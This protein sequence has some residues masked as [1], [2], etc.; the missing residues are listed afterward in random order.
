MNL[1]LFLFILAGLLLVL[2]AVLVWT[3]RNTARR[4]EDLKRA[5]AEEGSSDDKALNLMQNQIGQ[6]TSQLNQ[7]LHNMS[8]QFQKTTGDIGGTLGDVKK[9]LGKMEAATRQVLEKAQDI[10]NLENLLRAPKFRGGL[11]E[12]FLGDLLYRGLRITRCSTGSRAA[13]WWRP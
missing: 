1:N 10:A 9:D 2:F 5:Q 6:L 4:I 8:S 12:L 11:G 3:I 13:R 7:Q